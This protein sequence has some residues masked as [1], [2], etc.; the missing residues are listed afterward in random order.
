MEPTVHLPGDQSA[1]KERN[2]WMKPKSWR[3][4]F[5]FIF[6]QRSASLAVEYKLQDAPRDAEELTQ[7]F[8]PLGEELAGN[9]LAGSSPW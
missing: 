1:K 7:P 4:G 3:V 9:I 2:E 5:L 6:V 8:N